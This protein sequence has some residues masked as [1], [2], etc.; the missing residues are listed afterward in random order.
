MNATSAFK[1]YL[2]V[3][4]DVH[5][6][7]LI[8]TETMSMARDDLIQL[9]REQPRNY[10]DQNRKLAEFQAAMRAVDILAGKVDTKGNALGQGKNLLIDDTTVA[11][12]ERLL[13]SSSNGGTEAVAG[14]LGIQDTTDE[15]PVH[16]EEEQ[17][18]QLEEREDRRRA[19]R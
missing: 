16:V 15:Q 19:V 14:A 8:M 11:E 13:R 6:P 3:T 2:N 4:I 12:T 10:E 17:A 1:G 7:L 9:L 18:E 5:G